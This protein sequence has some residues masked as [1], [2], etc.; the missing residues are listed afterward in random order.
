MP[1]SLKANL[2]LILTGA[3]FVLQNTCL[4]GSVWICGGKIVE[5]SE[6]SDF[7]FTFE[8]EKKLDESLDRI[9]RDLVNETLDVNN[10]QSECNETLIFHYLEEYKLQEAIWLIS[11]CGYETVQ[12]QL[13]K[14]LWSYL[15]K[16]TVIRI[17]PLG[18]G[19][20]TTRLAVFGNGTEP[21]HQIKAV[22]KPAQSNLSSNPRSEEGCSVLDRL[23]GTNL[24]PM[25]IQ[26][27]LDRSGSKG[28][29]Q[30]FVRDTTPIASLPP[31]QRTK[32]PEM[33]IFD[34]WTKNI[35][36]HHENYLWHPVLKKM[37]GIDNGWALRGGHFF[38]SIKGH[39]VDKR[40]QDEKNMKFPS[41][42]HPDKSWYDKLKRL[43]DD[44]IRSAL[45]GIV[46]DAS[47][48]LLLGR[49]KGVLTALKKS[50]GRQ[51]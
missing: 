2:F 25:T 18:G 3:F 41:G 34:F 39:F 43:D 9:R 47:I 23:L 20:T 32:S 42:V 33:L 15:K 21:S 11:A 10:H 5:A 16:G 6:E 27:D 30:Y 17:Q 31:E 28:S 22:Y 40:S 19:A 50:V 13:E 14:V 51:I 35:D 29:V 44:Q 45:K 1:S 48:E 26:R 8:E 7:D 49:K 46:C 37:I 12:K 24:V 4:H 38:A 36:R